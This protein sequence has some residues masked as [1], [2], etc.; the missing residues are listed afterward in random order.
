MK[1]NG[2]PLARAWIEIDVGMY[3]TQRAQV[4]LSRGR[5][6]KFTRGKNLLSRHHVALSRGRGSKLGQS[7]LGEQADTGRPLARAWIEIAGRTAGSWPATVALSR[8]RGSKLVLTYFFLPCLPSRPLARAW[9]EIHHLRSRSAY[10]HV[11]LSR[12]RGSKCS[13]SAAFAERTQVALLRGRGSKSQSVLMAGMEKMS[14]SRE[15]VDRNPDLPDGAYTLRVALSRGRGSKSERHLLRH[16]AP[17]SPSREGVDRNQNRITAIQTNGVALSRGRGSKLERRRPETEEP[18]VALSRGRGS[19]CIGVDDLLFAAGR[20]LAR[21]WI[22]MPRESIAV[23]DDPSPSREGV[24][25]N[26]TL[27]LDAGVPPVAL[28]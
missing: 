21:A 16:P 1:G 27:A 10:R 6:S 5:G 22:E 2:R 17:E 28:S 9:I 12:G 18:Q 25:R 14:P 8:G 4:A 26:A 7:A 20:P 11:A 15:G 23:Y 19:K 13:Q 3:W 24:D